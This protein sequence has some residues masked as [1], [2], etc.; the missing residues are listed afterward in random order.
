MSTRIQVAFFCVVAAAAA[1]APRAQPRPAI[2]NVL[3]VTMDGMRWQEVF[4]GLQSALLT[5]EAGGVEE[6]EPI[7]RRFGG[8]TAEQR[9]EKLMPF[10]WTI[11][12]HDGQL[13]SRIPAT[14]SCSPA[15]RIRASTA[16][17]RTSTPT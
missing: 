10:F 15:T 6:P 11:V 14:T 3:V 9:R 12:A 2:A 5:K 1:I 8:G 4:G 7:E 13:F 17:T 16:T